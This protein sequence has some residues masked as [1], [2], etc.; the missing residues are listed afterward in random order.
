MP[1]HTAATKAITKPPPT[2]G[3]SGIDLSTS[4][5]GTLPFVADTFAGGV[6]EPAGG[7]GALLAGVGVDVA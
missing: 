1:T 4:P 3:I 6:V 2:S 5:V 7:V